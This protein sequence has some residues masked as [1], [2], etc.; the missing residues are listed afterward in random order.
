M[1]V[2][3]AIDYL[4][5][6]A[7]A[8]IKPQSMSKGMFKLCRAAARRIM[9]QYPINDSGEVAGW[10]DPEDTDKVR[11]RPFDFRFF[12]AR[13]VVPQSEKLV[14]VIAAS[15]PIPD[16]YLSYDPQD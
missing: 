5:S 9:S 11:A 4:Q 1:K 14:Q 12:P 16:P 3:Q 8:G 13:N 7:V 10:Y 2:N 6:V 15:F